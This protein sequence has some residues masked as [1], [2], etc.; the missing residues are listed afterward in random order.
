MSCNNLQDPHLLLVRCLKT[1]CQL[2]GHFQLRCPNKVECWQTTRLIDT[3]ISFP[4]TCL[5]GQHNNFWKIVYNL[6]VNINL[7]GWWV[8]K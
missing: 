5:D 8:G 3:M 2:V 6:L 7:D 4:K 1:I